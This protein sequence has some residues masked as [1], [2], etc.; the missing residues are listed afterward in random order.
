MKRRILRR[1]G[2]SIVVVW[3]VLTLTF[4]LQ[5]TL[6]SDPAR[7][8]AGPQ[9]RPADVEQIRVQLGLDRPL[10]V[11]YGRYMA[12]LVRADLGESHQRGMP[13]A[14]ILRERIPNTAMLAG[15]AIFLQV[16]L[17]TIAGV[18]AALRRG[19]WLDHGTIALTLLGISAPTFL[20]GLVLQYWLAYRLR[21]LPFDGFGTTFAQQMQ[22]M[23]L[24]A[25][26]LGLFGAAF[27]ARFVRDEM[28]G[29]LREDYIRTAMAKGLPRWR[30]ILVHGL[31]NALMPLLT[32]VGMDLGAM[33]GGAVVTEKLFRW[34]GIGSLTVDAVLAQDGPLI[35]GIVLLTSVAIVFA[36]LTVDLL[37]ALL[38]PR[39]RRPADAG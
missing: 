28:I 38:D 39:T 16:L 23:V 34:P 31:R 7:A 5:H 13:V 32:I 10:W 8:M 18:L 1:M 2:A 33:M 29:V 24:P 17:G 11:Q 6:P 14:D 27:Y 22:S 25:I 21:W 30:V 15:A 3:A 26:T 36:N 37:Y 12:R 35:M 19:T 9:A 4:V 20:T